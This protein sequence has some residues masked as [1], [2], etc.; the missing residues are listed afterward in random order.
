MSVTKCVCFKTR[1]SDLLPRARA[2]GWTT[3]DDIATA[4]GCGMG[5]RG[6]RPYLAA[7]LA[8]GATCFQV[9]MDDQPPQ[10]SAPDPWDPA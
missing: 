3:V 8:T 6:C 5:C 10:P 2:A 1:F 4:T 7:M 9:K